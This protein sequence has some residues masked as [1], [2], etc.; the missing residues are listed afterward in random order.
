[1][2]V[3]NELDHYLGKDIWATATIIAARAADDAEGGIKV[4]VKWADGKELT[5][6]SFELHKVGILLDI[7]ARVS[8]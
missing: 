6:R 5:V 7:I 4:R 8:S 2:Q 1:M 3:V